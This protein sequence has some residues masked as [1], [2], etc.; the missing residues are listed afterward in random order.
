MKKC[1]VDRK[2]VVLIPVHTGEL[3]GVLILVY[4]TGYAE[5][6]PVYTA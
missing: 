4:I 6:M 3:Y 1:Y 5:L 2:N